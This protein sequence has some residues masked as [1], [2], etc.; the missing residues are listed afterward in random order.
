MPS[1][2][3]INE[4]AA[5]REGV[6]AD[7]PAPQL[8]GYIILAA[9]ASFQRKAFADEWTVEQYWGPDTGEADEGLEEQVVK[10]PRVM[11]ADTLITLYDSE[12]P[13]GVA[14]PQY[15]YAGQSHPMR[16]M[17]CP[18]VTARLGWRP[19]AENVF[20]TLD[21]HGAPVAQSLFWRDGGLRAQ[22]PD[23]GIYGVGCILA[24]RADRIG[25]FGGLREAPVIARAW[26]AYGHAARRPLR[27]TNV[28]TVQVSAT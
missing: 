23:T 15:V 5:W 18:R 22:N 4:Q 24:V 2:H 17:L 7:I 3:H 26:R 25:A 6:A 12:A 10:L 27:E 28:A 14:R 9:T 16:L 13:W 20:S 1:P 8:P 11:T 19:A 21:E